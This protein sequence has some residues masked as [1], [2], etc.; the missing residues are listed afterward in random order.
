M[1]PIRDFLYAI[2]RAIWPLAELSA[3]TVLA[4]NP[5]ARFHLVCLD[6]EPPERSAVPIASHLRVST[7]EVR[8]YVKYDV[9]KYN[10]HWGYGAAARFFVQFMPHLHQVIYLDCDTICLKPV[11]IEPVR[12]VACCRYTRYGAGSQG[13]TAE[14]LNLVFPSGA[15]IAEAGVLV[16][17][18]DWMREVDFIARLYDGLESYQDLFR[19]R[20]YPEN[21]ALVTRFPDDITWLPLNYNA[22]LA[23][24]QRG[25]V[26]EADTIIYHVHQ[27]VSGILPKIAFV[28]NYLRTGPIHIAYI[29]DGSTGSIMMM[30]ISMRSVRRHNPSA[31]FWVV[32]TLPL[33]GNFRNVVMP[34]PESLLFEERPHCRHSRANL[35]KFLLPRLPVERLVY[36]DTD[37][38][39][40]GR[41]DALWALTAKDGIHIA[42]HP[43]ATREAKE[44]FGGTYYNAGVLALNLPWLR[45][46]D[47]ERRS[48]EWVPPTPA[49]LPPHLW[50]ADETLLNTLWRDAF[51]P[52]PEAFNV[53][54]PGRREGVIHHFCNSGQKGRFLNTVAALG[55]FDG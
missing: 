33:R 32:S 3:K 21:I 8:N 43:D 27:E 20:F 42:P 14:Y 53:T 55:G 22:G 41:L 39:C 23:D 45:L 29:T 51:A 18:V 54:R 35:L 16:L 38:F 36:L 30:E 4:H 28:E 7:E 48:L 37:T 49:E 1:T 31:R 17:N 44:L 47:F 11:D 25:R 50:M 34:L 19:H 52:M 10:F 40:T 46:I 5:Q 24:F 13:E 6:C 12:A 26:A 2:D 15:A 9:G